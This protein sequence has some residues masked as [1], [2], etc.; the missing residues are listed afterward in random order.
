MLDST[1]YAL[2]RAL[3][4]GELSLSQLPVSL[5]KNWTLQSLA[6]TYMDYNTVELV[7][8]GQKV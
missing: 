3:M 6:E 7:V 2:I 1:L 4:A 8:L 5:T